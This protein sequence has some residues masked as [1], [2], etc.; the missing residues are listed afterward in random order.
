MVKLIA[1][2]V[3]EDDDG[4]TKF[5]DLESWSE[6]W[7]S[8]FKE[9]TIEDINNYEKEYKGNY[10]L[11]NLILASSNFLKI[12]KSVPLKFIVDPCIWE[13]VGKMPLAPNGCPRKS[14]LKYC[15]A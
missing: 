14:L 9:I 4:F 8:L 3:D 1:G 12:L 5:N 13:I 7:R 11:A 6:Y 10:S 15:T 2:C